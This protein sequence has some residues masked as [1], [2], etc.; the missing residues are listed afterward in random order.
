MVESA[1]TVKK[2]ATI[3]NMISTEE[4]KNLAELARLE[5]SSGEVE[6]FKDDISS[7]LNYVESINSINIETSERGAE[8][9]NIFREDAITN[10]PFSYTDSLLSAAPKKEGA[11]IKVPKI[12]SQDE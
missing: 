9:V 10:E 8:E 1:F 6:K 12:L 5:L 7:V 3:S 11:Y 4:V 2:Y